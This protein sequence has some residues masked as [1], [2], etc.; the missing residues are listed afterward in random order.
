MSL[1][2]VALSFETIL[3]LAERESGAYGLADS[4]LRQRIATLID[5]INQRGPYSI[6][7]IAAMRRQIQ[8]L[9]V[10]R[11]R[12]AADR[13]AYPE[14]TAAKPGPH[15]GRADEGCVRSYDGEFDH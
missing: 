1:S 14:I 6:D 8:H 7:Q 11:L 5:W 9:L 2:E 13:K 12:I 10:S 4:G 15:A 3:T